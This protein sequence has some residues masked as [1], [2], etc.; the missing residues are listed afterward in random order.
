MKVVL[1]KFESK[2]EHLTEIIGIADNTNAANNFITKLK[3]EFPYAYG[4]NCGEFFL[5]EQDLITENTK[6]VRDIVRT[7]H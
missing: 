6:D 4:E 7:S 3:H 1:I 5:E 2:Y